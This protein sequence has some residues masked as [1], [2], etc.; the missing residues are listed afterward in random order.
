MITLTQDNKGK[1]V[2][3]T[4]EMLINE[5]KKYFGWRKN[6]TLKRLHTSVG[7]IDFDN[8]IDYLIK[9]NQ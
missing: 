6:V 7:S 9:K 2:D 4:E 1:T 5:I 8:F 3:I